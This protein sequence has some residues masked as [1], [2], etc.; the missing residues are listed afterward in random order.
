MQVAT[1]KRV[2]RPFEAY[3]NI[4]QPELS[5]R[6]EAIRR[7]LGQELVILGHHYQRDDVIC[8]SD[9]RGDSFKLSE[10][11]SR[12]SAQYIVFCGVHFMAESADILSKPHQKVILPDL[13]AG[14]SMADMATIEQVEAAWDELEDLGIRSILPITYMNSTA[15]VKAFCGE[16]GG[17]VCTSSNAKGIFDWAWGQKEKIF[18][19]PDQ[20]LGRN[21]A[22]A[23]GVS[24]D[25]MVVWD[26]YQELG[27]NSVQALE[28]AKI[29][30]WKGHCSVHG[31][32]QGHH[33]DEVRKEHKGINV[34]VH[35]ECKWEVVEKADYVGST[36]YI[37]KAIA[38]SEPGSKW[39][40]GTE[41]NLVNRLKN[42]YPDRFVRLLS[43]DLCMCSTMFRIAPEN[44]LWALDN[45]KAGSIVNQITVSKTVAHW[46]RAALDRMLAVQ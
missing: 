45:L 17:A 33:V 12:R 30:L 18:F 23:K 1:L 27:G 19:F 28:K 4:S 5:E 6:I 46:A 42:E 37:I 10:M 41:V 14:C 25:D 26:P 35:P 39:A 3:F 29:I 7:E 32:F 21:T 24:L 43:P 31:R 40:V 36:E 2:A 13:A 34:L 11:A 44:L 22:Y 16:R 8:H 9:L 15:A 20:H 38:N